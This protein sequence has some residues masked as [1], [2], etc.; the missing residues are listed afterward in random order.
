[1]AHL[2]SFML[3][4]P[5]S[6]LMFGFDCF[7][8]IDFILPGMHIRS[9]SVSHIPLARIWFTT[10]HVNKHTVTDKVRYFRCRL[11]RKKNIAVFAKD[12]CL[13]FFFFYK[14][15]IIMFILSKYSDS[16]WLIKG[17][18][19]A[20]H[21]N[22]CEATEC[23]SKVIF[24]PWTDIMDVSLPSTFFHSHHLNPLAWNY[25]SNPFSKAL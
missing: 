25:V 18:S 12:I 24:L 19:C 13:F 21:S 15:F 6:S 16:I 10:Q 8:L 17:E 9:V 4:Y 1:M 2:H 23:F 20:P 3:A 22:L 14:Y 5:Y 11:Q 7:A